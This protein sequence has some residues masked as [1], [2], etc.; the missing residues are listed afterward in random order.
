V[1][2]LLKVQNFI[3]YYV[4]STTNLHYFLAFIFFKNSGPIFW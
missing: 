2:S 3:E 1:K 4:V